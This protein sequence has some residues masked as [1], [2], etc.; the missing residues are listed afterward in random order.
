MG[1][2]ETALEKI[3]GRNVGTSNVGT[4]VSTP[5]TLWTWLDSHKRASYYEKF[6]HW[7]IYWDWSLEFDLK[8][9]LGLGKIS[10]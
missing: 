2:I 1:G 6:F 8:I 5:D 7:I 3:I 4:L 10:N 9:I